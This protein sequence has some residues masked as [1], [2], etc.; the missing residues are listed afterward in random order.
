MNPSDTTLPKTGEPH[1]TEVP[2]HG[3]AFE[4][5][6]DTF[7]FANETKW[8]YYVDPAT[9][10][11]VSKP[12]VPEPNYTLHCFVLARAAKQFRLHARFAPGLP[13]PDEATCR[14]LIESVISRTAQTASA[15]SEKIVVPGYAG[16]REF[17]V[18]WET[19]LKA[20]CGGAWRSYF[21]RGNWRMVFPFTRQHQEAEAARLASD[22]VRMGGPSVVHVVRFPQLTINHT[23][24][25]FA[26]EEAA[27]TVAFRAYDPNIPEQEIVL[28]YDRAARAFTLPPLHYF[29]GGR[30]DVY[31]IY[32]GW[33]Y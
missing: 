14:T 29:A 7:A 5:L 32:R 24:L 33:I 31:E 18:A 19:L 27:D 8:S 12:R 15:E 6:R 26:V 21:Q 13:A 2:P 22:I 17:S 4:F 28:T 11:Q 20:E 16:L 3:S 10:R 30:L 9:G 23:L 25:L 1:V